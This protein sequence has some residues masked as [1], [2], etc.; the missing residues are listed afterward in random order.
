MASRCLSHG[1]GGCWSFFLIVLLESNLWKERGFL[2]LGLKMKA[3]SLPFGKFPLC[4][5]RGF[6]CWGVGHATEMVKKSL[7]FLSGGHWDLGA[8]EFLL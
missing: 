5:E 8:G 1:I 7:I 2:I 4:D 3:Q 6:S